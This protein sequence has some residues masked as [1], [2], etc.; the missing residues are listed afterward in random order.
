MSDATI[1]DVARLAGVSTATVSKVLN[2][3]GSIGAET[4]TRV[5]DA[6]RKLNYQPNNIARSLR[7]RRTRTVGIITDDLEGVFTMSMV[8]GLETYMSDQGFTAFV[9]NSYGHYAR[10]KSHID[11]L[12][13]NR[14]DGLVL[15]SG[16]RV[17][18]RGAPAAPTGTLPVVY[19]YQY[20][21]EIDVP[22]IVPDD[23]GGGMLGAQRLL[24]AGCRRVALIGGPER[25]EA[26]MKRLAGYRRALEASGIE[27]DP[28][29]VRS[30]SWEAD[31]GYEYAHELM[32]MS[33][34]PDGIFCA[35]DNLAAGALDA[36]HEMSIKV[37]EEVSVIGFDN[38]HSSAHE[39]PPLT[40]VALPLRE[41]GE[42]A[43]KLLLSAINGEEAVA[44][45]THLV[46]CYVI[47]RKSTLPPK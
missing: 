16:Y 15:M 20:S 42:L 25:Y 28:L 22:C 21:R 29:L 9:C 39:R 35:S 2:S 14:V 37:P 10:E 27:F 31:A 45:S 26:S 4:R 8:R 47:E 12:L 24:A 18:E 17:R 32:K 41:M 13:A 33:N 5:L 1:S 11:A 44:P 30:G 46:P 19:L 36:L 40:T 34:P 7:S 6:A 43:G 3:T 23:E 38:R